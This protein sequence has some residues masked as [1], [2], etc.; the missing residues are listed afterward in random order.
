MRFG[1]KMGALCALAVLCL[2]GA[3]LA[4]AK[5]TRSSA[6]GNGNGN[7]NGNGGQPGGG[8]QSSC[9]LGGN[10]KHVIYLQFDNV[11][12][13]RD[14]PNVPSDLEQMPHLLNFLQNNGTVF[15]N[16]HTILISHTA[17]G[18][19]TSLT[20]LYPDRGG[21]TVGNSYGY[22]QPNGSIGFAS[23]FK[24]WNDQVDAVNDP[25]PNMITDGQKN[26]PA[27]WVPFTRAGCDVGGVG[28]AN[29]ELENTTAAT[30]TAGPTS[31][32][33]GAAIGDT[34]IKVVSVA[35]FTVGQSVSIDIG[36]NAETATIAAVGTAGATG[37]GITLT[38]PLTKA[39]LVGVPVYVAV[40]NLTGDMSRVF[41]PGSPEW[42]EA[43][44]D[45]A[46]QQTSPASVPIAKI[47]G[48]ALTDFVGIAI[49]CS[50]T[51]SSK[52]AGNANARTDQL[53]DEPGGY[54]GYEALYGAKYVDPAITGGNA[55]VNDTG[56]NQ[57][58]DPDGTCGFP[59]FDGME[60]AN[61]LGYVAQ[62]QENGVPVTY[63]YISDVH[64]AHTT[65]SQAALTM[66]APQSAAT[67]PGEA[68]HDAQLKQY[69]DAF[70]AFFTNL[71]AHGIDKSNTLFVVTVDE[72]DH[73]AGGVGLPAG[74]SPPLTYASDAQGVHTACAITTTGPATCPSNQIGEVDTNLPA[75]LPTETPFSIHND[76]APNFYVNPTNGSTSPPGRDDPA[77]R[78]LEHDVAGLQLPDP[79]ANGGGLTSVVDNI[80]DPVEEQTLHMVN[81]DP[82]RT[83][84]FTLFGN[85]D[86]FFQSSDPFYSAPGG[87]NQCA[88]VHLC[89]SPAFA[90]NHGDDQEV[91]GNTWVGFVGPG[92]AN[93]GIDST[94][95]T[96][97]TNLRP[98]IMALVGLKDDYQTDGRVLIEALTKQATPKELSQHEDSTEQLAEVYEQLNAPF[99]TFGA[100]TLKASTQAIES[101]DDSTYNSIE[102][103]IAT[104]TG[105]R[106]ALAK[107]ISAQLNG[108]AFDGT[109]L[110]EQDVKSE[111]S[112]AN[113]LIAQATTLGG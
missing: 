66:D 101:T 30:F 42:T 62:M 102:N 91:I 80:A 16:D 6:P 73:F 110:K 21:P 12:Y 20:G 86:F 82:A 104:L 75:V 4:A 67:G 87:T 57:I 17:D 27:P 33:A 85:D 50:Q 10:I 94:T 76:D 83:P 71:A 58:T 15:T 31:I 113:A 112:Q 9:D 103:Q 98:T 11:H 47:K 64:D 89:A 13:R 69:D 79:Y 53:P 26:T 36:A 34:N 24:Y 8:G 77:V 37:T 40:P 92:V 5:T 1:W 41:G 68:A 48:Q 81:T 93:N 74:G 109:Q 49:H 44:Q 19:L 108:A 32:A 56:G 28:T 38:A 23:A 111:I 90:W 35:K 105:Q 7:G 72:G 3:S 88:G 97:H 107:T 60:A 63:G 22:F 52:C 61:T 59:G 106:D 2:G 84:T 70:N 18:I 29:I 54:T 99:G 25:L 78:K 46:Y 45:A 39:H 55:C 96:D 100:E 95:W 51:S 43:T 65:T 14:A